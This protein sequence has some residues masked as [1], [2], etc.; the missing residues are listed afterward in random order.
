MLKGKFV[1][2]V[3]PLLLVGYAA[4]A[5]TWANCDVDI[6][7]DSGP[8]GFRIFTLDGGQDG[9]ICEVADWPLN[10]SV[11]TL[12]CEDGSAPKFELLGSD[13]NVMRLDGTDLVVPADPAVPCR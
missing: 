13:G 4:E 12:R 8:E 2:A 6:V 5:K 7:V 1:F 11:A 10:S 3:L 9:L